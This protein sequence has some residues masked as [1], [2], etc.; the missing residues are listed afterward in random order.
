VRV[1]SIGMGTSA[2]GMVSLYD[3]VTGEFDPASHTQLRGSAMFAAFIGT[4]EAYRA[5]VPEQGAAGD[6]VR[7]YQSQPRGTPL[8]EIGAIT[9]DRA[10]CQ[11]AHMLE[12]EGTHGHMVCE[13][14]HV[15]PGTFV[16]LDLDAR[17]VMGSQP[18][19]VFP[20]G[21]VLVRAP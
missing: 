7:I 9:L 19:G 14:D 18:I 3:P 8:M 5:F 12:A 2:R 10:D 20:D 6:A 15:N 13:G 11:K 16:W 4:K 21:L 1:S 17:T